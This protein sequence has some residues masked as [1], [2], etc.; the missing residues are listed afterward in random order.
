MHD[1]AVPPAGGATMPDTMGGAMSV[2]AGRA[3]AACAPAADPLGGL[4]LL[5]VL[6]VPTNIVVVL[7]E[8]AGLIRGNGT[9]RI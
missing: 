5:R 1:R 6:P 4:L 3:A 9:A 2:T 8:V 7:A